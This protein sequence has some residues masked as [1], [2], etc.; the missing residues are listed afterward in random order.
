MKKVFTLFLA[1]ILLCSYQHK[2]PEGRSLLN[3]IEKVLQAVDPDVHAGIEVVSLKTKGTLFQKNANHLFVPASSLKIVTGAAALHT[4]GVDYRF[5]TRLLTDGKKRKHELK[6]NL[7]IKGSGDPELSLAQLEELVFALK[8]QGI[9]RIDGNICVDVSDFDAIDQAPG[10]MWD[11]GAVFYNSP[12]S[13]LTVNHSCVDIWVRPNAKIDHAPT[14]YIRPRT[15]YVKIFSDAL[16][17]AEENSLSVTRRW[18]TKENTI[19]ITGKIPSSAEP[20]YA[21]IPV[22]APH[23]YTAFVFQELL[24]K[25][26]IGCSGEIEVKAAPELTTELASCSSRP[27][28][29]IVEQMMKESDNLIADMLFK[30]IGQVHFGGQGSW[31]KGTRAVRDFLQQQVGLDVERIVIRDGSGLSR[32]NQIAPHHLIAALSYMKQQ[33]ACSAEFC[34]SLPISGIDGS[35][36]ERMQDVKGKIRAKPGT[37]TGIS[38]LAGYATTKDGEDL[39]FTIMLNGFTKSEREYK[40]QIEDKICALLVNQ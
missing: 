39:A 23:M 6:G 17:S 37:M 10:W 9:Q 36:S 13:A 31:Q 12:L 14:I 3:E 34:A 8:L 1:C 33:F 28:S 7:Y 18:M 40:T 5:V 4:L 26:D 30:K 16:V 22:E 27:L 29:Q 15:D 24:K 19:D 21:P 38:S 2:L 11:E 20:F 25:N 35:L 32:Y